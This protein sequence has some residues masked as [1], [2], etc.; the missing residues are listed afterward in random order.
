MRILH[1]N[2]TV[3]P[4]GGVEQYLLSVCDLLAAAGHENV[5][6]ACADGRESAAP[7]PTYA[8]PTPDAARRLA[9][10]LR[11]DVAYVHHVRDGDVIAAVAERMPA[12]G[13]I[14]GFAPVC[15]GLGKYFRRTETICTRPFGWAC[16][17]LQYTH[18]CSTARHPL[19]VRRLMQETARRRWAFAR[20]DHLLVASGYMRD[21][22]RQNRFDPR[23]I[24]ILPPHFL[25]APPPPWQPPAD[26]SLL[27]Y[28]GRL[29]VEKGVSHLLQ[30]L[31]L[32]PAPAHLVVAGDGTQRAQYER[33]AAEMGLAARVRFVGWLAADALTALYRRCALVLIPSHYAEPFGKVGIEALAQ[34]RAVVAYATGGIPE[35]LQDGRNGRLVP[36]GNVPAFAQA[37]DDLLTQPVVLREMGRAGQRQAWARYGADAHAQTLLAL[38]GQMMRG[39]AG[40]MPA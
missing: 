25:A 36:P 20:L 27:V 31:R 22:L 33:M 23:R 8:T 35:W 32:L 7:W 15:A 10:R 13:Y 19:T 9:D 16:A 24:T 2:D 34:G 30:A 26:P 37:I 40:K 5:V 29:E 21:L 4:Q 3:N 17:P 28:A 12:L 14:H 1:L 18:R 39:W 38:M 11:P 6:A